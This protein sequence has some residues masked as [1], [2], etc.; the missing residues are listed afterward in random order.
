[1]MSLLVTLLAPLALLNPPPP[2]EP[3]PEARARAEAAVVLIETFDAGGDPRGYASGFLAEP[4]WIITN[5]HCVEG[6]SEAYVNLGERGLFRVTGILAD[7]PDHDFVIL[8]ADLPDDAGPPLVLSETRAAPGTPV[9][10]AVRDRFGALTL[11]GG[12]A[13]PEDTRYG[14]TL[15]ESS[16]RGWPGCS[17]SPWI[18]SSGRAVGVV[19]GR[20]TY[21]ERHAIYASAGIPARMVRKAKLREPRP[22]RDWWTVQVERKM[23]EVRA[24]TNRAREAFSNE[25]YD[26]AAKDYRRALTHMPEY[27]LLRHYLAAALDRSGKPDEALAALREYTDRFPATGGIMRHIGDIHYRAGRFE[28]ARKAYAEAVALDPSA[29]HY[30]CLGAAE[31]RLGSTDAARA[32]FEK[33]AALDAELADARAAL[34]RILIRLG[35]TGPVAPALAQMAAAEAPAYDAIVAVAAEAARAGHPDIVTAAAD[36]VAARNPYVANRIRS[37]PDAIAAQESALTPA[38]FQAPARTDP[39]GP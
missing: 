29:D 37:I 21:I 4:N 31:N 24:L 5:W 10:I 20:G 14:V 39:A 30:I 17:G 3:T 23:P 33:A 38:T 7:D 8:Q 27:A 15:F 9:W 28:A 34:L 12:E 26:A 1:M 35:E 18:D 13:L 32:A 2:P 11:S 25:K 6:A 22:L 36:A 16:A 19:R